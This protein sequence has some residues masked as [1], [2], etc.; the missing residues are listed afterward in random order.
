MTTATL[1]YRTVQSKVILTH[2]F[3]VN[4]KIFYFLGVLICFAMLVFYVFLINHLTGGTYII[5]DY[6]KQI[7][8]LTQ[9]NKILEDNFAQSQFLG[10]VQEKTQILGFEKTTKVNYVEILDNSLAKAPINSIK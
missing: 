3:K 7:N 5:K 8:T 2:L 6:N 9:E 1:A 4:W 10:S